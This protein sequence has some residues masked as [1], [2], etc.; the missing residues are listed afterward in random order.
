MYIILYY[1]YRFIK[2]YLVL[3]L[4]IAPLVDLQMVMDVR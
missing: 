2:F 3:L 4:L 1:C